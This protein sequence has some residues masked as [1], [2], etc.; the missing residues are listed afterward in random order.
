MRSHRFVTPRGLRRLWDVFPSGARAACSRVFF[1]NGPEPFLMTQSE[2]PRAG[3][4]TRV[5]HL[6]RKA[7]NCERPGARV[8]PTE[9]KVNFSVALAFYFVTSVL[10]LLPQPPTATG[11]DFADVTRLSIAAAAPPLLNGTPA[12]AKPIST[13]QS[14]PISI[15]SLK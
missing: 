6:L 5:G 2:F 9:K 13:P 15:S 3:R 8:R 10:A 12:I 1:A 7:N 14:V 4:R 11:N